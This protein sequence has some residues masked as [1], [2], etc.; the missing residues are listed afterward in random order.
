MVILER[1][2]MDTDDDSR[3]ITADLVVPEGPGARLA[4]RHA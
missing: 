3:K 4:V 2:A 1:S